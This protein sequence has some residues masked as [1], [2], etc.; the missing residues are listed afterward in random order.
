MR[1]FYELA[2]HHLVFNEECLQKGVFSLG[3]RAFATCATLG[4]DD[5]LKAKYVEI[6]TRTSTELTIANVQHLHK[7]ATQ[8][9]S[10]LDKIEKEPDSV[11]DKVILSQ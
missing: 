10:M 2:R 7:V 9:N 6:L 11:K 5:K 4:A 1:K 8:T 3:I